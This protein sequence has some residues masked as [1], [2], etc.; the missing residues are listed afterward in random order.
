MPA[1]LATNSAPLRSLRPP[2]VKT[3][4]AG[5]A[6]AATCNGSTAVNSNSA[7]TLQLKKRFFMTPPVLD[8]TSLY[9]LHGKNCKAK[10]FSSELPQM[11]LQRYAGDTKLRRPW[12]HGSPI[13]R[14][15]CSSRPAAL[16]AAKATGNGR[17]K[18]SPHCRAQ[19]GRMIW[20]VVGEDSEQARACRR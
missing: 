6:A 14:Q 16:P 13:L 12:S 11:P 20:Q 9:S 5:A 19:R 8:W 1:S 2:K 18:Q 15:A 7:K 10:T 3:A 4:L 17:K